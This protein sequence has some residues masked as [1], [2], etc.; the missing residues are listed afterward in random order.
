MLRQLIKERDALKQD[1]NAKAGEIAI[2]RSKQD[3][4]AKEHE[5]EMTTIRKLNEEKLAKQQRALEAARVAQEQAATEREFLKQDLSEE[6]E[7]V[8]RLKAREAAEKKDNAGLATPKKKKALPHRDGFDD[9][10]IQIVSPS[11]LSPSKFHKKH[12][13]PTRAAKRKRKAVDSPIA[14]LDVIHTE[15]SFPEELEQKAPVLDEAILAR[16]GIQDDRFDV[17][18]D[19]RTSRSK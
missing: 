3:K 7:R 2:V 14:P 10:E 17:N 9:D 4:A 19:F 18:R 5:R 1:L 12:G 8:R 11:K 15:E 13:T 6:A 16:L